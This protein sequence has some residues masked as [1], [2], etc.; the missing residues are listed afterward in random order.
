[1]GIEE[2]KRVLEKG[3][4]ITHRFFNIDEYIKKVEGVL[5]DENNLILIEN[6]FWDAR[7]KEHWEQDWE[8]YV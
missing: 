8:L 6:E 2:A 3:I 1:M 5:M 4:F 7:K